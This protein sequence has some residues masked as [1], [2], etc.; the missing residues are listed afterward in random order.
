M[1]DYELWLLTQA[2]V[3]RLTKTELDA[4]PVKTVERL[5]GFTRGMKEREK[6][7]MERQ[8]RQSQYRR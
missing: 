3:V 6:E 1:K 2:D 5:V 7:E 4:L 8:K